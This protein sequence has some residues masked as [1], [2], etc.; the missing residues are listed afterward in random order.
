METLN[1]LNSGMLGKLQIAPNFRQFSEKV[2]QNI[3]DQ[4]KR[5]NFH[6]KNAKLPKQ[7]W[8]VVF[9]CMLFVW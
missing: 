6:N 8:G 5:S 1:C 4:T 7:Q 2:K 3:C 9:C